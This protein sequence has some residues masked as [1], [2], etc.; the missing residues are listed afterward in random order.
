MK[1]ALSHALLVCILFMQY[2]SYAQQKWKK[3]KSENYGYSL[4]LPPHFEKGAVVAG[5]AITYYV[6]TNLADVLIS[7]EAGTFEYDIDSLFSQTKE[8]HSFVIREFLQKDYFILHGQE[9][10]VDKFYLYEKCLFNKGDL[11]SLRIFYP[12][13]NKRYIETVLPKIGASFDVFW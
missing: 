6:D 11:Y 8:H 12:E 2:H 13:G 5:G 3:F 7:V 4:E 10:T 1:K 9:N